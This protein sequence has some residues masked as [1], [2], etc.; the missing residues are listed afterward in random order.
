VQLN[1]VV[2]S[3]KYSD[4]FFPLEQFG[5]AKRRLPNLLVVNHP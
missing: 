2:E 1:L 4:Y 5:G 3:E